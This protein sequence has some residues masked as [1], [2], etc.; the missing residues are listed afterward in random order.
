MPSTAVEH[1]SYDDA[2]RELHVTYV[3]GGT[4]TYYGVPK[5]VYAAFCV[6][7]SKGQFINQFA[8]QQPESVWAQLAKQAVAGVQQIAFLLQSLNPLLGFGKLA[9]IHA[10]RLDGE[11]FLQLR[12]QE[13]VLLVEPR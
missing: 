12:L 1:I 2:T 10:R 4:Y 7:H 9:G 3:G 11:R 8:D 5:Q 13:V 6:A